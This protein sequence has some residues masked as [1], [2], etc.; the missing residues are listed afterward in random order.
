MAQPELWVCRHGETEWSRTR[1]HTGTTDVPLTERGAALARSLADALAGVEVDLVLTS[2]RR[3][4]RD[5]AALAGFPDAAPEPDAAEWDYGAYEGRT[6]PE[7]RAEVPGWDIWT[8]AVPGGE[9]AA[10]VGARA[11]RV[12]AR[13]RRSARTRA[14]L[15][16]HSH[17]LRVL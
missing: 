2:P 8:G 7:I 1:R 14:L 13:V 10:D 4:A 9:S 15:F 6:T 17:L 3:R 16:A 5:T 12:I 11:D